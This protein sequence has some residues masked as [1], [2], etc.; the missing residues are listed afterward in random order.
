VSGVAGAA[1]SPRARIAASIKV[2]DEGKLR[3]I[4]SSGSLLIDEG[5]AH[6]TLPGTVNIHFV[7]DGNPT[8]TATIT[9]S[10]HAGRI[11]ARGS[12]RLS[13]PSSP[14][15]SFKG[16]LTITGGSGR[17][18]HAHGSGSFYGVFYRRSYAITVQ[19]EGTMHY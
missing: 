17:Y 18:A 4:K 16:N 13:N 7:Y 1:A 15:P 19:T 3:L 6:G 5:P 8:V 2:K 9:I 12:G 10:S 14:N 11:Q